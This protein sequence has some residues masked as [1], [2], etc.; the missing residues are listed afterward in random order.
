MLPAIEAATSG[1][2]GLFRAGKIFRIQKSTL[3]RRIKDKNKR[4]HGVCK[5]MGSIQT[6]LSRNIELGLVKKAGGTGWLDFG[7]NILR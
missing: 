2:M 6:A 4:V 3:H 1:G 5:G 7:H